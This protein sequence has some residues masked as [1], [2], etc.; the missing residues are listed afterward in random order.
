MDTAAESAIGRGN[1][2][3][4]ADTVGEANNPLGD[5]LGVRW[6]L[7]QVVLLWVTGSTG[8]VFR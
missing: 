2:V 4:P 7:T 3:L 6:V 5:K 8:M 1:D